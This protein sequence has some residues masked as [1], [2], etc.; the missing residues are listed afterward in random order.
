MEGGL[1]FAVGTRVRRVLPDVAMELDADGYGAHELS[2]LREAELYRC[3]QEAIANVARHA[4]ARTVKIRLEERDGGV[5]ATVQDD[6]VGFDVERVP[7][8]LGIT[9]MRER[10]TLLNGEVRLTSRPGGG[11]SVVIRI[12]RSAEAGSPAS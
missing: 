12:P 6:G 10:A 4:R 5:V 1:P 11:T 3:L 2:P 7:E 9:G 8:G